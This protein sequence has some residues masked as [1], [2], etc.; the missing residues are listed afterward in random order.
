MT[1]R[2]GTQSTNDNTSA[3]HE[4]IIVTSA[5]CL[6]QDLTEP[7]AVVGYSLKFPEGATS[8]E[9]FWQM[10]A[11]GR[12]AMSDV[13]KERFNLDAFYQADAKRTGTVTTFLQ[14][15]IYQKFSDKSI[16]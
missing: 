13:P 15:F 3:E 2:A 6:E 7:I 14:K 8:S 9:K 5:R 11:N 4:V 1:N 16:Y 10:L 12:S